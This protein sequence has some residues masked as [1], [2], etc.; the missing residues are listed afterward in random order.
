MDYNILGVSIQ[1]IIRKDGTLDPGAMV[2][3]A[4]QDNLPQYGFSWRCTKEHVTLFEHDNAPICRTL[5]FDEIQ[6]VAARGRDEM[7]KKLV[8]KLFPHL[9]GKALTD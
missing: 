9:P 8:K 7:D 4:W 2:Y 3:V 1:R 6:H 5:T